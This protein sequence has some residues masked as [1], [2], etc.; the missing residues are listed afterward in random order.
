MSENVNDAVAEPES[1]DSYH[2]S[3]HDLII[4]GRAICIRGV[5]YHFGTGESRSQVLFDNRLDI[6][7][8]EVVIMTGP[9]GSGKTTLLTL[10][11]GLRSAQAGSILVNGRELVGASRPALVAHRRQ[12]GFI[13][14]HHN[15]FSSLTAIENVRMATALKTGARAALR[16]SADQILERLGLGDRGR[17]HPGRLSGGQRQRVAIARALVNRPQ[18]VLA[19][20]PTAALDARSGAI[21]MELL[22]DL[23]DGPERSTVLIVTHDQRLLDHADRIV[24]MVGGRIVSSVMPAMTIRILKTISQLKELQGLSESTLTRMADVMTVE[25]RRQGEIVAREGT[26]GEKVCVIGDG[27][28]EAIKDGVVQR[29]LGPGD[30]YGV[31]TALSGRMARE[32]VRARTDLEVYALTKDGFVKVMDSDKDYEQRIRALYMTRQ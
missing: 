31:F 17:Y 24:S 12:I 7:K 4:H 29:E 19:D 21:V 8:G 30:Y 26:P 32:T 22:R 1:A 20:E 28:A 27:T 23:A 14:Q 16:Q 13:F 18:L 3:V 15:L 6:G 2:E 11:G 10:I 25:H 5:N 9:S